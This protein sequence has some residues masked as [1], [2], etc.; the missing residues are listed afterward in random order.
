MTGRKIIRALVAGVL[1]LLLL[2]FLFRNY[3]LHTV[4]HNIADRLNRKYN[5]ELATKEAS[6]SGMLTVEMRDISITSEKGDTL[7]KLD[8]L[9][10]TPSIPSLLLLN[11]R[12]K[13]LV[14]KNGFIRLLCNDSTCN[15]STLLKSQAKNKSTDTIHH[16]KQSMNYAAVFNRLFTKAFDLAPQNAEMRNLELSFNT[17]SSETHLRIPEFYSSVE[18]MEGILEDVR[19]NHSW[20]MSGTFN[21]ESRM[22]DA[23]IY[24]LN[25]SARLPVLKEFF[26]VTAGF[27]T[28]RIALNESDFSGNVF[29][30]HGW[31]SAIDFYFFHKR[32]SDDTV[33]IAHAKFSYDL[34][35]TSNSIS[36]DS[37][38]IAFLNEINIHPFFKFTNGESNVYELDLKTDTTQATAFFN[39]LPPGV[40]D[41]TRGIEADGKLRYSLHFKLDSK[42][43]DSVEFD[44]RM[45]KI[46]FH[47]LKSGK[48]NLFKMNGEFLHTVYE[49]DHP[50][51]SF[52]VGD[53]NPDFTPLDQIA[54]NLKNAILTSED[55]SFFFHNGFNEE[56]FRK[57]IAENYRQKKF[58]R[59]GSTISMQLVKNVFLSRHKTIA[60]KAEEAL[61]VWLI[62]SNRLTSK[63]RMFE[64]YLNIIELGPGIYG[65]G[66]AS[67]FYFNKKPSELT[68][69][70][71][72]FLASLLP[73]PKW[74]K[75]SFDMQG[76][77]KPYLA[78]YYRVVSNFLL[79]RNLITQE[80]Y[81][82]IIPNVELKGIAHEMVVPSDTIPTD[83]EE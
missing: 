18:K 62:E 78:D 61:I 37:T 4:L 45:S 25:G 26:N 34:S 8:S 9:S 10:A 5:L 44:S 70:E 1:L 52:I 19:Q 82:R 7:M 49:Y 67:R 53:S 77:L 64:V 39:S 13:T 35:L 30:M 41:E 2:F 54:Q 79:K 40:F 43:P 33:K 71:S 46:K 73:H 47:L 51:R 58:V 22:Y 55:G 38:S 3:V 68:L 20:K 56:A 80:E 75:Y 50:Y 48:E 14:M 76:N 21:Q 69:S 15:Y 57:S 6:F 36:L 42:I 60:R 32:I 65:V 66:E 72:I 59:G 17:D 27:D 12:I 74:F 63:E 29:D 28:V 24:P 83:E 23:T 81:D 31:L 11:V 16:E